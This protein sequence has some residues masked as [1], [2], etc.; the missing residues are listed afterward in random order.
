MKR[1]MDIES[2][3]TFFYIV[4]LILT[5][6]FL[7]NGINKSFARNI[8]DEVYEKMA[9][10][11]TYIN[12]V[13]QK[14]DRL[15]SINVIVNPFDNSRSALKIKYQTKNILIFSYDEKVYEL[16]YRYSEKPAL[17]NA[18]V[19]AE[20]MILNANVNDRKLITYYLKSTS[21]TKEVFQE[22]K[23]CVKAKWGFWIWKE[24]IKK[25]ETLL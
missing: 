1:K 3:I 20:D 25:E 24:I 21:A 5:F 19:I 4:V 22:Y 16:Y 10:T 18:E 2:I 11:S 15:N 6:L 17:E 14:N 8:E 9:T 13:L 23:Y 7:H 12:T